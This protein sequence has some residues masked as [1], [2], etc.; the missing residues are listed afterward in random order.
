MSAM[1]SVARTCPMGE[2]GKGKKK[3]LGGCP[4]AEVASDTKRGREGTALRDGRC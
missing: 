3:E 2:K 1:L 4:K